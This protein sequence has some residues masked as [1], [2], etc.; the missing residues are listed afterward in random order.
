MKFIQCHKSFIINVDYIKSIKNN[1]VEL[2][3]ED[4]IPIGYKYKESL[5]EINII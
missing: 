2:N 1:F 5:K 4:K 3:N